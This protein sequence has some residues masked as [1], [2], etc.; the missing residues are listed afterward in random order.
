MAI[1]NYTKATYA[2]TCKGEWYLYCYSFTLFC[3]Q[4]MCKWILL[5]V[6]HLLY[7][8]HSNTYS[9]LE[10]FFLLSCWSFVSDPNIFFANIFFFFS[11]IF[12]ALEFFESNTLA[13]LFS[14]NS[15]INLANKSFVC[16]KFPRLWARS[17]SRYRSFSCFASRARPFFI[18]CSDSSKI[19]S[20][21]ATKAPLE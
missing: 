8:L 10:P 20:Y 9:I 5:F 12:K 18:R 13:G 21:M 2:D 3:T 14:G 17:V 7:L 15:S 6:C 11:D 4:N 16:T 19:C 1:L